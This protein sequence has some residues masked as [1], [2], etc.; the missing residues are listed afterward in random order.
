MLRGKDRSPDKAF[1]RPRERGQLLGVAL[2]CGT[3]HDKHRL[4]CLPRQHAIP[5]QDRGPHG[6]IFIRATWLLR[7]ALGHARPAVH[8]HP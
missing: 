7:A 4:A 5:R 1:D 2:L 6:L 3:G 8:F